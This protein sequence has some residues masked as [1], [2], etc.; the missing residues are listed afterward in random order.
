MP[1]A[2][3]QGIRIHY[4]VEGS[5]PPLVLQHGLTSRLESWYDRGYVAA[6]R[7]DYR[8]ILIDARGHGQSDKPHDATLH[9]VM[10]MAT[11]VIAVLDDLSIANAHYF[12]YSMG[13]IIGW[14]LAKQRPDR[15]ASFIL[16]GSHPYVGRSEP[17]GLSREWFEERITVLQQGMAAYVAS[18]EAQVGPMPPE[19]KA[20]LLQND[21]DALIAT[22]SAALRDSPN[23][24]DILRTMTMPC[25][26]FSGDADF[27]YA[28]VKECVRH[29]P[30]VTFV[31]LPGLNHGQAIQRSDLVL[32]HVTTFLAEASQA[33]SKQPA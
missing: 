17:Y 19:Q 9:G 22:C 27:V 24:D 26:V 21:A 16:G 5:G 25:L 32:P 30:N 20:L 28:G 2:T 31:S 3:N 23:L 12:G 1:Y 6:L 15:I 14:A 7:S 8:L 29:M 13:G 33:T 4:E 11:D 18:M 10:L